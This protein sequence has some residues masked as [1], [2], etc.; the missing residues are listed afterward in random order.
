MRYA[1][2]QEVVDAFL[3]PLREVPAKV[4]VAEQAI[5]ARLRERVELDSA[6]KMALEDARRMLKVLISETRMESAEKR[7]GENRDQKTGLGLSRVA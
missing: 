3:A 1:W 5:A 2:Q 4:S 7:S 6:E